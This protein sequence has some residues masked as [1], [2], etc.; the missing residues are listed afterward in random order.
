MSDYQRL[1][2]NEDEETQETTLDVYIT[3][4]RRWFYLFI[5]C[6]AQISNA[7]I[8]IN[9]SPIAN[10]ASEYYQVSY[11]AINWL[12]LIYMV[13]T[14]PFT[15]PST[16]FIDRLGVLSGLLIGT[17]MNAIGSLIRCLSVL[18][19]FDRNRKF[20]VLM[21][22]Q[23]FCALAQTFILFIP[24]KFC[25]LWFSEKQRSFAN[26]IAIGSGFFGILL[27]S[28]L[29][30]LIASTIGRI[31]L[32]LYVNVL[33]ASSAALLCLTM[34]SA[35]PPTPSCKA[36][37][38][39]QQ[40]FTC[41]L[42]RLF[43]SKSFVVLFLTCGFAIGCFNALSTLIEQIMC[44]YGYDNITIGFSLGWFI[45]MGGLGS[46][47]F[48]YIADRTGKLSE[49]SKGLYLASSIAYVLLAIF[50]VWRMERY[51]IYFAFA[52]VGFV[53]LSLSPIS[54]DLTLE[55]VY[56]IPEAT[57]IGVSVISSQVI[58][59][60]MVMIFPKFA[61]PLNEHEMS[62]E[63]CSKDV[64]HGLGMLNYSISVY[65]QMDQLPY[66]VLF[67]IASRIDSPRDLCSFSR[68]CSLFSTVSR[69]DRVWKRLCYQLY[70]VKPPLNAIKQS[71][72]ELFTKILV[73]Y[74]RY[75]GYWKSDEMFFG[76]LIN[77]H[78][79][80]SDGNII[81]E[82]IAP[83]PAQPDYDQFNMNDDES[84][85]EPI[86]TQ[87]KIF[88]IDTRTNQIFCYDC[89][90]PHSE[91]KWVKTFDNNEP[92][93]GLSQEALPISERSSLILNDHRDDAY[94]RER[95]IHFIKCCYEH[96][97]IYYYPLSIVQ[98]TTG[99]HD[100]PLSR[101]NGLWVGSYGGHGLELLHLEFFHEFTYSSVSDDA[102]T[103]EETVSDALV[104]RKISGDRNVPH[105]KISFAAIRPIEVESDSPPSYEGIGQ[106]AH[107]GYDSPQFIRT[108]VVLLSKD[109]LSVTWYALHHTSAFKRCIL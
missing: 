4:K 62:I 71:F 68:V 57:A 70:N 45:G 64:K 78:L 101:L 3:Y 53:S 42:K 95:D 86:Y 89:N 32:L 28:I 20:G 99:E 82:K 11:N 79:N 83:Y 106:I 41:A 34:R 67:E 69:D 36:V 80:L 31:P 40:S 5:V 18:S 50:I 61:R 73:P 49:I 91:L 24:T 43:R 21:I 15:L 17:W 37:V 9:F 84:S 52:L 109:I 107:T 90:L 102:S 65:F 94:P 48:G 58:G 81:G 35:E 93:F 27:G 85:F 30:P 104:A 63:T 92:Y 1:R 75:L 22:G 26:S 51:L 47:L 6:L 7:M 87:T 10:L 56:P 59:I 96:Q 55:C 23:A 74:G 100:H 88:S 39:V 66:E 25:F 8:W 60:L 103:N 105:G 98:P 12:S 77:V 54:M 97:I 108:K 14:V 38:C 16:W 46:L 44:T 72:Y 19:I 2:Q 33:P 29:S 13:I 76:G